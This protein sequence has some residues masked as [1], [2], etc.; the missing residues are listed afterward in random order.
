MPDFDAQLCESLVSVSKGGIDL[1]QQWGFSLLCETSEGALKAGAIG[2]QTLVILTKSP[3]LSRGSRGTSDF[4]N[5][6]NCFLVHFMHEREWPICEA[7]ATVSE[8][9]RTF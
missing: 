2:E 5:L 3:R 6:P 9:S 1:I 4:P 7:G 8:T